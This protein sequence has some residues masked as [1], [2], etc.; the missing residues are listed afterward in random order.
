MPEGETVLSLTIKYLTTKYKELMSKQDVD[1]RDLSIPFDQG[2]RAYRDG[3]ERY[4]NP[5]T[6]GSKQWQSWDCGY[7]NQERKADI[8]GEPF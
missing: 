6:K 1:D 8:V 5:Y 4:I 3:L 7:A 2:E